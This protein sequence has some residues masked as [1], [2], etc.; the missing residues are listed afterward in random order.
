MTS[1]E[2]VAGPPAVVNTASGPVTLTDLPKLRARWQETDG[3][4]RDHANQALSLRALAH[5][6]WAQRGK[7]LALSAGRWS[8][9]AS[10]AALAQ[11]ALPL[12]QETDA[13]A[14]RLQAIKDEPGVFAKVAHWNET[15]HLTSDLNKVGAQ[16]DP[17]LVQ[18][19]QGA[20][21]TTL[22]EA[23][24]F[25]SQAIA[26]E[27]QA[28]DHETQAKEAAEIATALGAEIQKRS[29]SQT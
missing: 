5:G 24:I 12:V 22:P 11:E 2:N 17:V 4:A 10:L 3:R 14:G 8:P 13:D 21:E 18:L 16:L 29:E 9:P 23:D 25:R 27:S 26:A 20:P 6:L 28:I 1:D 19:G 15:R 7:V